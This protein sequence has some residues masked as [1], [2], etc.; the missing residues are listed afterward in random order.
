MK[1]ILITSRSFGQSSPEPIEL[2]QN[3]GFE[4]TFKQSDSLLNE[5][6]LLKIVDRYDAMI[7]GTEPFTAEVL[8]KCEKLQI[9]CKHG[10]G[11]DNIDLAKAKERDITVTNAPGKNSDAV[12][13]FTFGLI[14]DAARRITENAMGVAKGQWDKTIGVDVYKKTLGIIGF[15]AIGQRVAK[16]ASGFDMKV[17]VY[18]STPKSER[19]EVS[20]V[21]LDTL[22][23]ELDFIS[24]HAPLTEKTHKMLSYDQM[25]RVKKG[26]FIINTARGGIVDEEALYEA[27]IAGHLGGAAL[28]VTEQEPLRDSPLMDLDN[29]LITSHIAS[30]SR[31]AINAVSMTCARNIIKFYQGEALD[32]VVV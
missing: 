25:K 5:E 7:I 11:L 20:F 30:N 23:Q 26:A 10:A 14:L 31:E 28:D 18:T 4:L 3:Q 27:L 6:D 12:A 17:M 15:G 16:R 2:L 13:D 8:E 21:D 24:I 9:L 1:K 19:S 32:H 22:L 29:A